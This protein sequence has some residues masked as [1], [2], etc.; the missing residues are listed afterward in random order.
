MN[1]SSI[2][3]PSAP[4]NQLS[5]FVTES[6]RTT[7]DIRTMSDF[8]SNRIYSLSLDLIDGTQAPTEQLHDADV[9]ILDQVLR[10]GKAV[11]KG[12]YEYLLDYEKLPKDVLAKFRKGIY[13]LGESR[14]VDG[15]L[16]AVI[17]N[18]EGN[19]VKDLTLRREKQVAGSADCMQNIAIQYQLKQIDQKLDSIL[20]LQGYQI[21]FNRNNALVVPFFNARDNVVHAQNESNPE[22]KRD[23]LDTAVSHLEGALNAIYL[24]IRTIERRFL[25]LTKLPVL[26]PTRVI[27]Q[28]IG[29]LAQD[30]QLLAK[31]NSVLIQILDYMGKYKDKED[32]FQKYRSYMLGFYTKAVGSKQLP[33][34]L[35]IHNAFN[36]TT[37]LNRNVWK[38][39]TDEMVPVLQST[40]SIERAYII[41]LEDAEGEEAE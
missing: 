18:E 13:K 11:I 2:S 5:I 38:A 10:S 22:R 32:A 34:S 29:Y 30:L 6:D 37:V 39:M 14:Q 24:D 36:S 9:A 41:S 15:N 27:D 35:L 17:V 40:R 19:R 23:Y 8:M 1:N 7:M 31:Y 28:Y 16:R 21:D 25:L 12:E 20:E 3:D 26:R 4:N 33:L